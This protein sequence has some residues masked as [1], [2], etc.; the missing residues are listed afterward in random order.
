MKKMNGMPVEFNGMPVEFMESG[1]EKKLEEIYLYRMCFWNEL[2]SDEM[3]KTFNIYTRDMADDGY[4][5]IGDGI[6]KFYPGHCDCEYISQVH[7]WYDAVEEM[8][9][10]LRV[11]LM[12]N[13]NIENP[14]TAVRTYKEKEEK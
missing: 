4:D 8:L 2:H 5:L 6:K 10:D 13:H 14:Y 12:Q 3:M 9:L 11:E 1:I 7:K